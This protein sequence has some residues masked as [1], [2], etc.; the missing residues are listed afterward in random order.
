MQDLVQDDVS[1]LNRL[2]EELH[3]ELAA[4]AAELSKALEH[5]AQRNDGALASFMEKAA[6]RGIELEVSAADDSPPE[7]SEGPQPSSNKGSDAKGSDAARIATAAQWVIGYGL[8]VE[9]ND[10][11]EPHSAPPSMSWSMLEP[12]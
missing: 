6:A 1:D 3:N 10:D 12:A 7:V 11:R 9:S 5:C 2:R 4:T 8:E